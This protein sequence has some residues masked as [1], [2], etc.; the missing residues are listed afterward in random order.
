MFGYRVA[1]SGLADRTALFTVGEN[2]KWRPA[3]VLENVE[4]LYL[5]NGSCFAFGSVVGFSGRQIECLYF[6]LDQIQGSGR[7][8]SLKISN[9]HIF[10]TGHPIHFMFGSRVGFSGS[11]DRIPV[12]LHP[13]GPN[14]RSWPSAVLYDF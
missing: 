6:R 2:P 10:T 3:A 7:P 13:I 12:A 8:P 9:G 14:P 4:W 1:I 11:L 5:C